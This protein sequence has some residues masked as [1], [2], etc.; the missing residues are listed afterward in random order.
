M[1]CIY[2]ES[3][4]EGKKINFYRKIIKCFKI[5]F[6]NEG[7]NRLNSVDY[8]NSFIIFSL[9]SKEDFINEIEQRNTTIDI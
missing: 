3:I 5:L 9:S 2:I 7:I 8:N 1:K 6:K 4:F